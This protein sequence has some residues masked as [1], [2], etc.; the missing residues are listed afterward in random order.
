MIQDKT[1]K[2]LTKTFFNYSIPCIIA[3]FLTSFVTIVDGMFI[4]NKLGGR[5]LAAVNLTLPVLYLLLGITIMIGL[6]GMTL[7]THSLGAKDIV[8]ARQRFAFTFVLNAVIILG[9]AVLLRGLL[10]NVVYI[11]NAK[12]ELQSY[13]KD[14]LG[15][16]SFFYLFMMMN[17]IFSMF[18]RGE[19]KPQLSLFFGIAGNIINIML[20]YL[21]I[22]KLDYGMKGAALATGIAVMI[23]FFLG[24]I[25]FLSGRSAYRFVQFSFDRTDFTSIVFNGSSEFIGQ[26]SIC[27]TTYLFNFVILRRI[28]IGGVAAFTII[29]YVFFIQYMIITGIAQGVN[30]LVSYSF[31]ARDRETTIRLLA[32]GMKAVVV[33]GT[34]TFIVLMG[35][36]EGVVRLF[37]GDR[38]EIIKIASG[39]MR[40]HILAFLLNG[41]NFIASAYFTSIGDAK[42]SAAISILRSLVLISLFIMV[43]PIVLGD[44]GIWLT[45]PLA[46]AVTFILSYARISKSRAQLRLT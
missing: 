40:I 24:C 39:G 6:G 36:T 37:A 27:I 45:V 3:M 31:G 14:Y 28:G 7:A 26:I 13:V 32:I 33:V 5:G 25:Y 29:G 15:T 35:C 2:G 16:M 17:I 46:E 38:S 19:G 41:Y 8:R 10:D 42:T 20:D 22:I 11:L 43:L 21:F 1:Q 18:I 34:I 23:P 30:T 9:M 4:G 12:E 44:I